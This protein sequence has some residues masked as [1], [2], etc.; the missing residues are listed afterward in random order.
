MLESADYGNKLNCQNKPSIVKI[1][2]IGKNK[3]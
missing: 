1:D 2:L 3:F